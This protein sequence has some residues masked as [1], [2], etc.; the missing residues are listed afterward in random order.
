MPNGFGAESVRAE[1]VLLHVGL[2]IN[3]V[4]AEMPAAYDS[5]V[6]AAG[7]AANEMVAIT[8][9][10]FGRLCEATDHQVS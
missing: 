9:I 4:D 8:A 7:S 3:A 2:T 6:F 10:E 1:P 5:Q